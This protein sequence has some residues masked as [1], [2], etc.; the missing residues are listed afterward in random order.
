MKT[1]LSILAGFIVSAVL[2]YFAMRNI[3]FAR[4]A[5]PSLGLVAVEVRK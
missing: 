1:R 5:D 4:L 3:D 2:L